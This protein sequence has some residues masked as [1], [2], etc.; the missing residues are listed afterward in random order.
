MKSGVHSRPID[1][2]GRAFPV[3]KEITFHVSG[4]IVQIWRTHMMF[5]QGR[6][7]INTFIHSYIYTHV[8]DIL[9]ANIPAIPT[10]IFA[11]WLWI[12]TT[13]DGPTSWVIWLQGRNSPS[14]DVSTCRQ[15]RLWDLW[16]SYPASRLGLNHLETLQTASENLGMAISWFKLILYELKLLNFDFDLVWCYNLI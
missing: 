13:Y 6:T 16:R 4:E 2:P 1:Y 8:M 7:R 15:S 5:Y 14:N 12:I 11:P 9:H 3:L 10:T